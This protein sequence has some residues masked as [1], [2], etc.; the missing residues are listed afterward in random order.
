[1]QDESTGPKK[2]SKGKGKNRSSGYHKNTIA[3]MIKKVPKIMKAKREKFPHLE[4][5][6]GL[7]AETE[8]GKKGTLLRLLEHYDKIL[9]DVSGS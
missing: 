1:M 9:R 4:K 6:L 8:K 3:N 7:Q 2:A 5:R